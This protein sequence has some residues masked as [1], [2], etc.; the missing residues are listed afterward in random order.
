MGETEKKQPKRRFAGFTNDWEERKL[1][2]VGDLLT[3]YPFESNEFVES[4][5]PLVRGMNVKR[6]YL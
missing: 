2:E 4:G 3:G 5:I 1:D 6:G